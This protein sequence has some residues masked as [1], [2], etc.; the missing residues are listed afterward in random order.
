MRNLNR[1][2]LIGQL[3]ADPEAKILPSG[4]K[5]TT[6]SIATNFSWKGKNGEWSKGVDYHKCVAWTN[7]AVFVEEHC[8]KG[9]QVVLEGKLHS[10]SW[11]AEDGTK[12]YLTEVVVRT[13]D[14]LQMVKKAKNEMDAEE[15]ETIPFLEEE[16]T[17]A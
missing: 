4:Q 5:K 10:R 8:K 14:R 16:V 3:T 9:D 13:I 11:L 2:T 12:K 17:V 7:C 15:M 1:V 6:F